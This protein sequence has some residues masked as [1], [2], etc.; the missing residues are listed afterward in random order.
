MRFQLLN[1]VVA[2]KADGSSISSS[3][4]DDKYDEANNDNPDDDEP[5]DEDDASGD[6]YIFD[7]SE[8]KEQGF[9]ATLQPPSEYEENSIQACLSEFTACEV[10]TGNNRLKCESCTERQAKGNIFEIQM[11]YY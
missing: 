10:L 5:E 7:D 11:C 1:P 4:D 3:S 2:T 6:E 8:M 9:S